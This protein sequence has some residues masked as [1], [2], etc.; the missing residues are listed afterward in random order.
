[1]IF[2]LWKMNLLTN[3]LEFGDIKPDNIGFIIPR[4]LYEIQDIYSNIQIKIIDFLD[5]SGKTDGKR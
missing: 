1:M 3:I 4:D 5:N 2:D